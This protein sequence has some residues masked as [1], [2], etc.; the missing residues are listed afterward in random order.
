MDWKLIET[1][2]KDGTPVETSAAPIGLYPG[3]PLPAFYSDG[4]VL[5][6]P[7]DHL[8]G[9]RFDP[10]PTHWRPLR[11]EPAAPTAAR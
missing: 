8:H 3:Y 1:A 7:N 5:W 9:C 6:S 4:W 10:Q 2:P 11:R